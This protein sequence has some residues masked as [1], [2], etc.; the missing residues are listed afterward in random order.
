[1][2]KKSNG[3]GVPFPDQITDALA[4]GH[5]IAQRAAEIQALRAKEGRAIAPQT[6][7]KLAKLAS[8]FTALAKTLT[9]ISGEPP[10]KATDLKAAFELIQSNHAALRRR[11]NSQ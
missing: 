8:E 2:S 4:I 3:N 1:M 11:Y 5:E 7:E 6:A 9:E 10:P